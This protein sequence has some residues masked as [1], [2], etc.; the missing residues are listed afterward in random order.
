[1]GGNELMRHL[2]PLTCMCHIQLRVFDLDPLFDPAKGSSTGETIAHRSSSFP[3]SS[4]LASLASTS[5]LGREPSEEF[6]QKLGCC[7]GVEAGADAGSECQ[8]RR[9]GFTPKLGTGS[10]SVRIG[11]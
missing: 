2:V 5:G 4:S 3:I 6:I 7:C 10:G 9:D 11:F 1:V 8:S